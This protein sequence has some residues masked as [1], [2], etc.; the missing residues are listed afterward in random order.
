MLEIDICEGTSFARAI[1]EIRDERK[2]IVV[3]NG[4]FV[5]SAVVDT[6]TKG[7]IFLLN[8]ENWGC[9]WGFRRFDPSTFQILI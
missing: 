9:H 5:E 4:Y 2:W 6:Q 7:A 3:L 1:E 8:K